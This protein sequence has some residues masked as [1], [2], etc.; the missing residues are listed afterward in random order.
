MKPRPLH[1][2]KSVLTQGRAAALSRR[3]THYV[4]AKVLR[5]IRPEKGGY[6]VFA[7][8]SIG[9]GELIVVWGGDIVIGDELGELPQTM[10]RHSIQVEENLYLV[11]HEVPE[12]GDFINH[13][14]NPNAG[15]SGQMSLVAIHAIAKGEEICYDYAMSDGSAYDEF[16]CSCEAQEC[17]GWVTGSD[18]SLPD[19]Q[20][21]Y[22]RFFSPYLQRRIDDLHRADKPG[23]TMVPCLSTT[24]AAT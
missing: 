9:A 16:S 21:R 18:W 14:C 23:L 24:T 6:G 11:P 1:K 13:S 22:A 5:K 7:S 15:L 20:Q 17:R 8:R 10:Q 12:V 3:K 4:S 2:G 19:L